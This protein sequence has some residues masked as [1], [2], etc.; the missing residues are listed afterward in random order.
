MMKA[1]KHPISQIGF[2]NAPSRTH[3]QYK[4]STPNQSHDIPNATPDYIRL[5]SLLKPGSHSHD[6]TGDH[7]RLDSRGVVAGWSAARLYIVAGV[8]VRGLLWS[9]GLS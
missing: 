3:E 7:R 1:I 9:P 5:H 4:H 8:V 2:E 6:F